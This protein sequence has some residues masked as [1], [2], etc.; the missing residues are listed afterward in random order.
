MK[1]F[2][3]RLKE[4]G[5]TIVA[6]IIMVIV[7]SIPVVLIEL[8]RLIWKPLPDYIWTTLFALFALMVV[9]SFFR[10]ILI[11]PIKEAKKEKKQQEKIVN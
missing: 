2:K 7:I 8:S 11:E 1:L 3:E 6:A 9:W 4:M 10:W 5:K